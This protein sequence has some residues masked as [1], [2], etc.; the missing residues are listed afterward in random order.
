MSFV[1]RWN[2]AAGELERRITIEQKTI[3]SDDTRGHPARTWSAWLTDIAARIEGTTG[4]KGE[5][6]R[7]MVPTATHI[8]SIRYRPGISEKNHRI[9]YP[10]K[11][12]T[13]N[14]G[15]NDSTTTVTVTNSSALALNCTIQ[16]DA[17]QMLVTAIS[18]ATLTVTRA[19]GGTSAATHADGANV[20]RR[21][22][23]N[24]GAINDVDEQHVKLE[25]VCI[26]EKQ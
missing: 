24:I 13:L 4:R 23:F 11:M 6:A 7:Q 25:L 9:V 22:L 5:I 21:R 3:G 12:T 18:G 1:E 19:Q 17:E 20:L 2:I 15:I 10:L 26:E 16:I 8:V 14:G